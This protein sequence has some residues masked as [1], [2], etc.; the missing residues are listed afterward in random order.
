[1]LAFL[2]RF[3]TDEIAKN[4]YAAIFVLM[5]LGSAC[6]PIP[7]EIVMAFGGALAS[8][9]FAAQALGAP[10][11]ELN[12]ILVMVVGVA[13]TLVGSWLAYGIGYA[14]GRPLIDRWG[15]YLLMRPHE[16]DRAHAWFE[17][18]GQGA[19][20]FSRM[21]PLVRAFISLPAGVAQ[22]PFARF[23]LYTFLGSL[24]W[25][26]AL[27]AA[28]YGLGESWNRVERFI[29]PVSIVFGI[30]LV[31]LV[32]WWVT[33]RMRERGGSEVDEQTETVAPP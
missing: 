5:L 30:A 15:R 4:G 21:L 9:T 24:P 23:T 10:G 33:K 26:I 7:S 22:M 29:Q 16:V 12:L 32:V 17:R 14:G 19:V 18:H 6:I 3:I 8:S 1:M 20:F 28:G 25:T 11:R 31:A 2:G 27:A 13:A